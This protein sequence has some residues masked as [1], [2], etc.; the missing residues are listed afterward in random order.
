LQERTRERVPFDWAL[1]QENLALVELSIA[2]KGAGAV[3]HVRAALEYVE[4][5]LEVYHP[6]E[7]A[8]YF[9]KASR[10]REGLQAALAQDG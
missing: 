2:Q 10:L 4:A 8:F 5:A 9:E 6:Q 7:S 1:T 3:A